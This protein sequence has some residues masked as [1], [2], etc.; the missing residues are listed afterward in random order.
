MTDFLQKHKISLSIGIVWLFHISAIVGITL[1]NLDWFIEKTPLNLSLCLF[2]FIITYPVDNIKKILAF[3]IFFSGG[4][5]AEWLGVNY[6]VL[7]GN[8]EYGSNFGPKLDG[9]PY[10]IGTYWALLTYITA[11]ILNYSSLQDWLKILLAAILMVLLDFFME[12]SAPIFDFWKF[13]GGIAPLE[14]YIAWF[15]LALLF[16]IILKAFKI[17]GERLFATHLYLAQLV[18]FMYFY[19]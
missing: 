15:G 4:M 1:G 14:N 12:H 19:F 9:V 17:R 11:S 6:G 7:F 10:L 18:F 16:Q 5:F 2:L 8:Y 13:E 3:A